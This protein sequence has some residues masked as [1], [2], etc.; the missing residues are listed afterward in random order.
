MTEEDCR[1][2]AETRAVNS[3][4]NAM[5]QD[6]SGYST[7]SVAGQ[8]VNIR[9]KKVHYALLPVWLLATKWKNSNY[10]FAMNGQTGKLIGDLPVSSGRYWAWFA[11]ISLPI[12]AVLAALMYFGGLL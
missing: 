2:R 9:R 1:Q 5:E 4:L 7:C 8:R 10:L 6:V 12:M 11:G 3:T